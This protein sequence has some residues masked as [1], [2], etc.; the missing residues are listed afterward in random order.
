MTWMTSFPGRHGVDER[1]LFHRYKSTSMAGVAAA[2]LMGGW[3]MYELFANDTY[4]WDYL[5]ILTVMAVVK[6]VFMIWYRTRE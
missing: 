4:R 6:W 1:F 3:F 2:F 5:V